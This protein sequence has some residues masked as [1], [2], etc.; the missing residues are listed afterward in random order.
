MPA[1]GRG[2]S[3]RQTQYVVKDL[4]DWATYKL[5]EGF[6]T[7]RW[8]RTPKQR[9]EVL[10]ES[11]MREI[12]TSGSMSE[13]W[14]RSQ[15][16]TAKAPPDERGGNGYVRPTATAPHLDSTKSGG[17]DRLARAS[18]V[19]SIADVVET[20]NR[21]DRG[22]FVY[23]RTSQRACRGALHPITAVPGSKRARARRHH[24][25]VPC[26]P[27]DQAGEISSGGLRAGSPRRNGGDGGVSRATARFSLFFRCRPRRP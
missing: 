14:K 10:S 9:R 16:R 18:G 5:Q 8:R 24:E 6:R 1:E 22:V 13:M 2:L 23:P 11:R 26:D 3:S 27:A 7:R 4:G 12:C 20:V 19:P 21:P 15:G 25:T 17:T